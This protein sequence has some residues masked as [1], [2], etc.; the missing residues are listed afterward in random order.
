MVAIAA[1]RVRHTAFQ[2]NSFQIDAFEIVGGRIPTGRKITKAELD[3]RLKEQRGFTRRNWQEVAWFAQSQPQ[4]KP[5]IQLP[6]RLELRETA[7]NT[8]GRLEILARNA[9]A[10]MAA[11]NFRAM[12]ANAQM[13]DDRLHAY[14]SDL[15]DDDEAIM[16]L[17]SS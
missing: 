11:D 15:E 1:P 5:V 16:L 8:A 10:A 6:P 17:L 2:K 14:L 9:H 4:A 7:D 3:R 13:R 12:L